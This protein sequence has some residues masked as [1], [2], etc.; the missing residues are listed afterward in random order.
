VKT[1]RR[2]QVGSSQTDNLARN[3]IAT[4]LDVFE[5]IDNEAK[6]KKLAH[7]GVLE[8]ARANA[9]ARIEELQQQVSHL[10]EALAAVDSIKSPQLKTAPSK[11]ISSKSARPK[12]TPPTAAP[13]TTSA[14]SARRKAL[15]KWGKV[16]KRI[17]EWLKA[18]P[19]RKFS[20]RDLAN[21]FPELGKQQVS[22][23]LKPL[24]DTGTIQTDTSEGVVKTKYY[25]K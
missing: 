10:D 24:R 3:A 2:S 16:R 21:A 11:P 23:F 7:R 17:V 13:A 22:L 5:Q 19:G 1:P 8:Q 9:L 14:K 25:V 20:A 4:A 18:R 12:P 15:S 6:Q